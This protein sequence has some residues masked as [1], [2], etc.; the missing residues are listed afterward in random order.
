M[1]IQDRRASLAALLALTA[2]SCT[3]PAAEGF[4]T[5]ELVHRITGRQERETV[6]YGA[7]A[8]R[9]VRPDGT[10]ILR[11]ADR[12]VFILNDSEKTFAE[13]GLDDFV[14]RQKEKEMQPDVPDLVGSVGGGG[15]EAEVTSQTTSIG[16]VGATLTK[17]RGERFEV[18]LW[19]S[20][21][22]APPGPRLPTFEFLQALGGPLALPALLFERVAGF[23]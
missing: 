3:R 18:E 14:A 8:V 2:A 5:V 19:L 10:Y 12:T 15:V 9:F 13:S 21:D 6:T 16:G 17:V 22:L 23:P 7:D 4:Q 1:A 20:D 11:Y